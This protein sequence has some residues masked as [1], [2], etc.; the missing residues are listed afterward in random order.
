MKLHSLKFAVITAVLS[1][2]P[3][4][5]PAR[6][7]RAACPASVEAPL[8]GD[9]FNTT[10][11]RL[12]NG[13]TVYLSPS[14]MEPRVSASIA[15]RAGSVDDPADSTGMAHY[16]EHMLFKGTDKLGTT[17]FAREKPHL[18]RILSM[19]EAL[20]SVTDTGERA[21]I[22]SAIDAENV[23]ACRYAVPNEVDLVFRQ[24]G[25]R[26]MNAMTGNEG[27][28]VVCDFPSNRAESWAMV[29]SARLAKPVFRMFQSEIEA[30]Y[31]EKNMSLDDPGRI[32]YEA[33][34]SALFR[35]HPYAVPVL[36]KSEHLRNPSL[37]KMYEFYAR[38]FVP[39]NMA[40]VLSGDFDR[41]K[42]LAIVRKYFGQWK[43]AAAPERPERKT[44]ALA[45]VERVTV[46]FES[47][48]TVLVGWPLPAIGN[49]DVDALT[50]MDMLLDNSVA[51]IIN[52]TLNQE[53]KVKA[54]GSFPQ[55]QN[56]GGMWCTWAVP[57][58]G[59][60]LAQAEALLM[61]CV[62]K[63]KEGKFS[64][65]DI[66]AIV[67]NYELDRK[68]KVESI[69]SRTGEMA[70]SFTN[71]REWREEVEFL[72]RVRKVSREDV[73][74]VANRYLGEGR[75]VVYR[76]NGKASLPR[77][78]KPEFTNVPI[79]PSRHSAEFS[80]LVSMPA[81]PLE[82]KWVVEGR[83]YTVAGHP[84]GRLYS[85]PNPMN[86][87]F[88]VTFRFEYGER[89]N[90]ELGWALSLLDLSGAGKLDAAA[91]KKRLYSLG[92][93][94]SM[95]SNERN[96]F[97]SVSGLER[98]M[99]E[100]LSMMFELFRNPRVPAGALDKMV[101][102]GIG[103]HEDNKKNPDAIF[104]ALGEYSTRGREGAVLQELSDGELRGLK[105]KK[106]LEAAG[107]LWKLERKV[108]YVGTRTAGDVARLVDEG[109]ARYLSPPPLRPIT[110]LKP[111][112]PRVVF[113][114]RDMV[115][116]KVSMYIP[117]GEMDPARAADAQFYS[118]Y[119]LLLVFQE[120]RESRALAYD[121]WAYYLGGT[122]KRDEDQFL[123][124]IETQ[125]DKTVEATELLEGLIL[126]PPL[127][128]KRFAETRRS[129]EERYRATYTRF[130]DIPGAVVGWELQGYQGDPRPERFRR[131][132]A[133]Q[134]SDL[135]AFSSRATAG[136]PTIWILG[137]RN[138]VDMEKLKGLGEFEERKVGDIF[139]Y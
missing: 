20:F 19:Y 30:V 47:E 24:L 56:E 129:L 137:N 12:D 130:R 37:K 94:I 76:K 114:H 83:D 124:G 127:Q 134:V 80:R 90:R 95:G 29:E 26:G 86:D 139:P 118:N 108:M 46:K 17:D 70:R 110:Y 55:F 109:R 117:G 77:M 53:Q 28:Y 41:A 43:P 45:G 18:D 58:K 89:N 121:V 68:S 38:E 100:S 44:P 50:V 40:V 8:P 128:E 3:L 10:V 136:K 33:L 15:I 27:I 35:G 52:L 97:V 115:Q 101:R 104:S 138:R 65:A 135:K 1:L 9:L 98:N 34:D 78:A 132:S 54:S 119:M 59:Q 131:I 4:A 51:G 106:L 25:F 32:A 125:A 112:K 120:A 111:E 102:N 87:L 23:E 92:T 60:S 82:P 63:V 126:A 103:S 36:G 5:A 62:K 67:T 93:S 66:K 73:V 57:R 105:Q 13:L 11:H 16:L 61:G 71:F 31:E 81:V 122:M 88:S 91:F 74:R 123:G 85:A 49:P 133:Y 48:E 113:C 14:R 99:E 7:E 79:D 72:D 69:G 6:A 42:M 39:S 96:T 64:E 116:S 84:W 107:D 75:V 2:I 21:R 22:Y